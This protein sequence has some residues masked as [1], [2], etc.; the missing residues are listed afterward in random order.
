M[1]EQEQVTQT[2]TVEQP[3]FTN[4]TDG[5]PV[6]TEQQV[7]EVPEAPT[8]NQG[9][10]V[11]SDTQPENIEQP[12]GSDDANKDIQEPET[13]QLN[14]DEYKKLK[15]YELIEAERQ[16]LQERLGLQDVNPQ[17]FNYQTLDQQVIN[18]GQQELL[19]LCNEYGVSANPN[20]F[21]ASINKLKET[22]PQKGYEL[23]RKVEV[24]MGNLNNKR[25]QIA[26]QVSQSQIQRFAQ[27]NNQLLNASPVL[28]RILTEYA[29]ANAGDPNIYQNLNT[30]NEYLCDV[31]REALEYGQRMASLKE[32]KAD[33]SKVQGGI[34][35][36][37]QS[38][39]SGEPHIFTRAE[40]KTM[41]PDEFAKNEKVIEEQMKK[42]LIV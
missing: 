42:G 7:N 3:T 32:A 15:E 10:D 31:Y 16:A 8:E 30:I 12:E 39:Y 34:V 40:L 19:R 27:E 41:S 38:G 9:V 11:P 29:Q 1:T 24:L 17:D 6:P 25:Q 36:A 20:E 37:P 5:L 21:E 33:T 35:T 23:E 14:K 4:N 2:T 18:S 22:N 26:N 28:N 13:V